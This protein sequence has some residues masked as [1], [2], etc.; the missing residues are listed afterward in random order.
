MLVKIPL[1]EIDSLSILG[2]NIPGLFT[3]CYES[4]GANGSDGSD[5]KNIAIMGFVE[6]M[7]ALAGGTAILEMD[8]KCIDCWWDVPAASPDIDSLHVMFAA[9]MLQ[10]GLLAKPEKV[11][12]DLAYSG[13]AFELAKVLTLFEEKRI[14][15]YVVERDLFILAGAM[16]CSVSVLLVL[17]LVL[18]SRRKL[19][20]SKVLFEQI[21]KLDSHYTIALKYMAIA[22]SDSDSQEAVKFAERMMSSLASDGKVPDS[23]DR[24]TYGYA[25]LAAG[26][27]AEANIQ[28]ELAC[29]SPLPKMTLSQWL[30]WGNGVM[31]ADIASELVDP[32]GPNSL[33]Q[34]SEDYL[35]N[36]DVW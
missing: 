32:M 20:A 29:G 19:D 13:Q 18:V 2:T 7:I 11:L 36:A 9:H 23:H 28:F 25:L 21:L 17:G 35:G 5:E 26:M 16:P 10:I 31:P 33:Y 15:S 8:D 6:R 24:A 14:N 1:D 12:A 30:D 3:E 22:S 27:V 34:D 4:D